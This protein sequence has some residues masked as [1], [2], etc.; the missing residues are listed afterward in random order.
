FEQDRLFALREAVL[1]VVVGPV[2]RVPG[3]E[4]AVAR[5]HEG[6]LADACDRGLPGVA[7]VFASA[8]PCRQSRTRQRLAMEIAEGCVA[9]V[10]FTLL[11]QQGAQITTTH[12]HDPL[13]YL[14][15]TGSIV[16]GLEQALEGRSPGDA[17]EVEIAPEQGFGKRHDA[18]VQTL[19]LGMLGDGASV[20][21]VGARL[22]AQTARGPLDVVV[23]AV[24]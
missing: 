2:Q 16:P 15:G 12:G 10:H 19:P 7:P 3:C 4:V 13:V 24:D 18:L 22:K 17:F 1:G 11:D 8:R 14:H 21:A 23:T 20:P 6:S 5:A 9:T